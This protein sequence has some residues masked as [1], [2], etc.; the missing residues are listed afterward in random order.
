MA[1]FDRNGIA[2]RLRELVGGPDSSF[3][4]ETATRLGLEELSLRMSVWTRRTRR[5]KFSRP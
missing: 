2:E 4:A 5:S 3:L 1:N